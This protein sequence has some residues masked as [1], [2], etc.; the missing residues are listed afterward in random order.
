MKL[1]AV[2]FTMAA[3]LAAGVV[4]TGLE[5]GPIKS[6]IDS[7]DRPVVL[8]P[9]KGTLPA[10]KRTKDHG[11][12]KPTPTHT[13]VPTSVSTSVHTPTV[14]RPNSSPSSSHSHLPSPTPSPTRVTTSPVPEPIPTHINPPITHEPTP[15]PT[16]PAT[17]VLHP[18]LAIGSQLTVDA[19]KLVL[20]DIIPL[21]IVAGH[22][23]CGFGFLDN[24]AVGTEVDIDSGP[25]F[26]RYQV[27][28]HAT[29]GC[30][31]TDCPYPDFLFN[32]RY[33][34]ALQTCIGTTDIGFSLARRIGD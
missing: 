26:G 27:V 7:P 16:K 32:S 25:A 10:P 24:I 4:V 23:T 12:V 6:H 34:L 30:H 13:G 29:A 15:T 21:N 22:N 17:I 33:D 11:A 14:D 5:V 3:A 1:K 2:K 8:P 19:C 9:V 31:G 20:W 18:V 28:A